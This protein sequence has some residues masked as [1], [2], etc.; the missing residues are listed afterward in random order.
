MIGLKDFFCD[1]DHFLHGNVEAIA[2]PLEQNVYDVEV[3]DQNVLID[4]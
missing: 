2:D 4:G 1:G 3:Y